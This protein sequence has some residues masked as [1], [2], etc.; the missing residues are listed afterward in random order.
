M[1]V[2]VWLHE[3]VWTSGGFL[4]KT[5]ENE[6][7]CPLQTGRER[8][9]L[10]GETPEL[11][12]EGTSHT[13]H[14]CPHLKILCFYKWWVS[15][16]FLSWGNSWEGFKDLKFFAKSFLWLSGRAMLSLAF[17]TLIPLVPPKPAVKLK[18]HSVVRKWGSADRGS[19]IFPRGSRLRGVE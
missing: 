9:A 1:C 17:S 11:S 6:K 12:D 15:F 3:C 10:G 7:I 18:S 8:S 14:T 4:Q 5:W 13:H 19:E 2:Y 16:G